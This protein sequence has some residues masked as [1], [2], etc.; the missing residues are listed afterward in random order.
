MRRAL[1]P[2][3]IGIALAA[4]SSETLAP[5]PLVAHI[6][7]NPTSVAVGD[8]ITFVVQ[9]Q[10]G[11]LVGLE[12]DFGD[13]GSELYGTGGART[14]RVTFRYAYAAAGAYTVRVTITDAVA[15]VT[16]ASTDVTVN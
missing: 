11:A 8:S 6:D 3:I 14:A 12:V 7:A 5:L 15:G 13:G 10:G 2:A 1:L 16:E 4:C 9:A